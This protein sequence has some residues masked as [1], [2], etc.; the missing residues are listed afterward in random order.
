MSRSLPDAFQTC[1]VGVLVGVSP[2]QKHS[3]AS[4]LY[5]KN[6]FYIYRWSV[7]SVESTNQ[8]R[9]LAL[10]GCLYCKVKGGED[11]PDWSF[12]I[13]TPDLFHQEG[14]EGED[15]ESADSDDPSQPL[16]QRPLKVGGRSCR[17]VRCHW[18]CFIR[19]D[20]TLTG[21]PIKPDP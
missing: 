21:P 17:E 3:S 2:A 20:R 7:P 5:I 18:K 11:K 10:S 6:V 15:E 12:G 9:I 1:A 19:I 16:G 4:H 8:Q 13:L 14:H